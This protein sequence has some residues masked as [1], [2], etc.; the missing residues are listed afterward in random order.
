MPKSATIVCITRITH[1]HTANTC[2]NAASCR[3]LNPVLLLPLPCVHSY[4][5]DGTASCDGNMHTKSSWLLSI[6]GELEL[7]YYMQV[8]IVPNLCHCASAIAGA[9]YCWA[10]VTSTGRI[11]AILWCFR[12]LLRMEDGREVHTQRKASWQRATSDLPLKCMS[13]STNL[14][15]L[16]CRLRAGGLLLSGRR[17]FGKDV[18]IKIVLDDGVLVDLLGG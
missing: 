11:T 6:H 14:G 17:L 16:A 12:W 15:L 9:R 3:C 10:L 5:L 4:A 18:E 7:T 8:Y 2:W 1:V 13:A